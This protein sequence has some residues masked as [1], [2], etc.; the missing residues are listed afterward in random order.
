MKTRFRKESVMENRWINEDEKLCVL[1][2]GPLWGDA[3]FH[4]R[5]LLAAA[6]ANA[7]WQKAISDP[8]F[9][10][11][12]QRLMVAYNPD[13][14]TCATILHK[15][16]GGSL[17]GLAVCLLDNWKAEEFAM[18]ADMGFFV[19]TGERYQMTIPTGLTLKKIKGAA[20]KLAKTEDDEE[21]LHPE[22]LVAAMPYSSGVFLEATHSP[23]GLH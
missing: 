20:L 9:K 22:Y 3:A 1:I 7:L 18:M 16:L 21:N 15:Y 4:G 12:V 17:D 6:K 11:D 23:H 14:G 19:R 13:F 10:K 5:W 8:N 2:E